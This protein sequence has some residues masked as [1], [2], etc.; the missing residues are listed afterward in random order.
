MST[1]SDY[2][3]FLSNHDRCWRCGWKWFTYTCEQGV[4][5]LS[6][7]MTVTIMWSV[8]TSIP[9]PAVTIWSPVIMWPFPRTSLTCAWSWSAVLHSCG[10]LRQTH[11]LAHVHSLLHGNMITPLF[12]CTFS[13]PILMLHASPSL[14]VTLHM[15]YAHIPHHTPISPDSI[16]SSDP[17][18]RSI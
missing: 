8:T 3:N 7:V 9:A 13:A 10:A 5:R 6:H 12:P 1:L 4:I 18:C 15:P 16:T 2:V 14:Y 11:V 17:T